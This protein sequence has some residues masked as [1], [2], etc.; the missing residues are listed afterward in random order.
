MKAGCN[1]LTFHFEAVPEPRPLIEQHSQQGGLRRPG[2]QSRKRPSSQLEP[3]LDAADLF[4]VM[5]VEPG[6]GGQKFIPVGFGQTPLAHVA[7]AACDVAVGGRWGRTRDGRRN[8]AKRGPRICG[9]KRHFRSVERRWRR[10]RPGHQELTEQARANSAAAADSIAK[11]R[12]PDV[13]LIRPGCT[14]FDEQN[15]IQGS[16][17]LPLSR[18]GQEQVELVVGQ[19]R[20]VRLDVVFSAPCEPARSTAIAICNEYGAA[21][22][23][24]A[25]FCNVNHGLWQ[26]LQLDDVRRKYPKVFKQWQESPETVCLPEGET[27]AEA[28][29][30]IERGL[31]KCLKRKRNVGIVASEPLATMIG[32]VLRGCRPELPGTRTALLP[33]ER[34]IEFLHLSRG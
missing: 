11:K 10:L 20:G 25:D 28:V 23:E 26:G 30:R 3:L 33:A 14:D 7:G 21:F 9:R 2:D 22:K 6:F 13:V 5:S 32:C 15:R 17:D 16:L 19:L 29:E 18:R 24:L 8:G 31:R 1:L 4:L 34:R 12:M 27:V